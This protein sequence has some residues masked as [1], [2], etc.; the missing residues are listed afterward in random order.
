MRHCE[1]VCKV[2]EKYGAIVM[3]FIRFGKEV[4]KVMLKGDWV[5]RDLADFWRTFAWDKAE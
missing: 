3:I 1:G 4:R 5:R 2:Y